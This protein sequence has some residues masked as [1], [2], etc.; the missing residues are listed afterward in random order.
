MLIRETDPAPAAA[1]RWISRLGRSVLEFQ[2]GLLLLLLLLPLLVSHHP[3][4][5]ANS[6][7]ML[8]TAK[9]AMLSS[10]S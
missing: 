1:L 3:T 2:R 4:S 10:D 9:F 5:V 6:T 8:S 7:A